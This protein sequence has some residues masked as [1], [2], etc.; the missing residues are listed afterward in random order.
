MLL[1]S[2]AVAG[3][4]VEEASLVDSLCAAVVALFGSTAFA[5]SALSSG[6]S[7]R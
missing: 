1:L 3:A 2:E 7:M 5:G 4:A 6:N